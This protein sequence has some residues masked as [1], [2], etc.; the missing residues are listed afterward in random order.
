MAFGVW[1]WCYIIQKK[2]LNFVITKKKSLK[3]TNLTKMLNSQTVPVFSVPKRHRQAPQTTSS[4][5]TT[6]PGCYQIHEYAGKQVC[7]IFDKGIAY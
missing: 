7:L 6:F 1:G 5:S 3:L 2:R 4:I